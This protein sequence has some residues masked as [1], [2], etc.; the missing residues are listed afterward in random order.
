MQINCKLVSFAL[1]EKTTN[2]A[3]S[4]YFPTGLRLFSKFLRCAFITIIVCPAG[5]A[6]QLKNI[7]LLFSRRPR[8]YKSDTAILRIGLPWVAWP[9]TVLYF[10]GYEL[11]YSRCREPGRYFIV[12]VCFGVTQGMNDSVPLVR[13]CFVGF[14]R[15]CHITKTWLSVPS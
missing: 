1:L 8:Y 3:G 14:V 2:I 6:N 12:I 7:K 11:L 5:D 4:Y 13:A 9:N 15:C 10:P